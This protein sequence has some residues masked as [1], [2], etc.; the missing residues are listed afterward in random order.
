MIKSVSRSLRLVFLAL[1]IPTVWGC[2]KPEPKL[3]PVSG[4][5]MN[6]GRPIA[7]ATVLFAAD[8]SKKGETL[9]AYAETDAQ[10]K[11]TLFTAQRGKGATVGHYKVSVTSEA[12]NR[13]I[14]AKFNQFG[15]S[16]LEVDVPETGTNDLKLDLSK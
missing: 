11:F 8:I 6:G 1:W 15:T 10:G 16:T 12:P 7:S 3:V 14:P 4:V 9:D 13:L 5:V 2:G